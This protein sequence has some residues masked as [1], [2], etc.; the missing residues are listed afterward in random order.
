[1]GFGTTD[2]EVAFGEE[3]IRQKTKLDTFLGP[4]E[5]A[6]ELM[7]L[8][9]ARAPIASR[10][11]YFGKSLEDAAGPFAG[12]IE[13]VAPLVA[14]APEADYLSTTSFESTLGPLGLTYQRTLHGH[15]ENF[16]PEGILLPKVCPRGGFKFRVTLKFADGSTAGDRT[17]V[18]CPP[19]G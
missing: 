4:P 16:H 10:V 8:S 3:R 6:D 15:T 13:T 17:S 1:M 19:K 11:V 9:T 12:T 18:P 14:T 2:V 5:T 7:F